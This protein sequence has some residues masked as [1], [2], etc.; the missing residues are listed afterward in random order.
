MSFFVFSF[1]FRV[2]LCFFVFVFFLMV[3][4]PPRST[5]DRSS[6]ASDVYK[7]Q[8]DRSADPLEPTARARPR[9]GHHDDRTGWP[10]LPHGDGTSAGADRGGPVDGRFRLPGRPG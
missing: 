5:L 7:R 1:L 4:A 9:A 2:S 10:L 3:R 8:L 6:A